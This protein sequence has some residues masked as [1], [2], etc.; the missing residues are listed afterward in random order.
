[1][2]EM[3]DAVLDGEFC[4][5]CGEYLDDYAPGYP[6]T[7][8]GCGGDD[9]PEVT[10]KAKR[11][12]DKNPAMQ[13]IKINH[14]HELGGLSDRLRAQPVYSAYTHNKRDKNK[15]PVCFCGHVTDD[16]GFVLAHI[17]VWFQNEALE[18]DGMPIIADCCSV[19][20]A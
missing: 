16:R 12:H 1:M 4:Q 11:Q 15:K 6:R 2:G 14:Q 3:A 9:E 13:W 17:A 18:A 5:I 10:H 7:C 19:D 20:A 8:A